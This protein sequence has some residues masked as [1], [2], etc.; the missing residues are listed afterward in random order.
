VNNDD[1]DAVVAV[2]PMHTAITE[3]LQLLQPSELVLTSKDDDR[4]FNLS[5][6]ASAFED[7]GLVKREKLIFMVLG[8]IMPNIETLTIVDAKT[9]EEKEE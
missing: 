8:E 3:T 5:I 1:D 6:V 9:P 2:G 4:N 7:L